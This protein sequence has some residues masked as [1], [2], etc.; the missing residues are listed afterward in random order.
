MPEAEK[1]FDNWVDEYGDELYTWAYY[2]TS[3]TEVAHD[4]VQDTFLAALKAFKRFEGRS[5]TKTWLFSILNNKI[6]DHYRKHKG[7]MVY[8]ADLGEDGQGEE[9]FDETG[10]WKPEFAPTTWANQEENLLDNLEFRS[11]LDACINNLSERFRQAVVWKYL[12]KKDSKEI[13][14]ELDITASNYWQILHRAKLQLRDCLSTGWF[15]DE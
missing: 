14:K 11:T 6:R 3:S 1:A 8:M 13:C 15:K 9:R 7:R 2:K 10:A 12:E 4:L 5:S